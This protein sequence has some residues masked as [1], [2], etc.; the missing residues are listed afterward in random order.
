MHRF[1]I[2]NWKAQIMSMPVA[3]CCSLCL[4][5]P[6]RHRSSP[7]VRG[8]PRWNHFAIPAF[9]EMKPQWNRLDRAVS[10]SNRGFRKLS[11][12]RDWRR[13][14]LEGWAEAIAIIQMED[15]QA[16]E[17]DGQREQ[18]RGNWENV[19]YKC[20]LDI[21]KGEC[22]DRRGRSSIWLGWRALCAQPCVG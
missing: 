17:Q 12:Q 6:W 7:S 16:W 10:C 5:M 22:G 19:P 4:W 15:E 13:G 2:L 20:L 21:R 9:Q 11:L 3:G 1:E 8:V 14:K 18:R